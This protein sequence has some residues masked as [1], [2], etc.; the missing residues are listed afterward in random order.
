MPGH[1][2]LT[3]GAVDPDPTEFLV[4]SIEMKRADQAKPYDSRKSVWIPDPKVSV[5]KYGKITAT[6]NCETI[7]DNCTF[8]F[9]SK[10]GP[11]QWFSFYF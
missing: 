8:F 6:K 1:I 9:V 10:F 4:P 3:K 11:A 7:C 2:K 5:N